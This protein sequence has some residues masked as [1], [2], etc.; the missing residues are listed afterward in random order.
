MKLESHFAALS[1]ELGYT[2]IP[3]ERLVSKLG[4]QLLGKKRTTQAIMLFQYNAR[5]FPELADAYEHLSVAY[6]QNNQLQLA[7]KSCELALEKARKHSDPLVPYY[8]RTLEELK[9]K[10]GER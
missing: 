3:S 1:T 4:F 9:K 7:K 8:Q 10:M 2:V 5:R 6:E